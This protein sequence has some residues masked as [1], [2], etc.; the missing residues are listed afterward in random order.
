MTWITAERQKYFILLSSCNVGVLWNLIGFFNIS[1][2]R[3]TELLTNKFL[4][5]IICR[6][7]FKQ[8]TYKLNFYADQN[9]ILI[10]THVED[11]HWILY[12]HDFFLNNSVSDWELWE[13]DVN[14][15]AI[16]CDSNGQ[17]NEEVKINAVFNLKK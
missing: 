9:C 15:I 3:P 2:K 12:H 16:S 5:K 10:S 6:F 7:I 8:V 1:E 14:V 4:S 11:K 13:E 17:P